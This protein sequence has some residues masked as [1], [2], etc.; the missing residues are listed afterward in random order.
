MPVAFLAV[1][2]W[3]I[4]STARCCSAVNCLG[5][6]AWASYH[7]KDLD[8]VLAWLTLAILAEP[9]FLIDLD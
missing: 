5:V 3:S 7:H 1:I 2:A 9:L 4:C 6:V 8:S